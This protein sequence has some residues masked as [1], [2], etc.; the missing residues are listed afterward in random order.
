MARNTAKLLTLLAALLGVARAVAH[1]ALA[2]EDGQI[3]MGITKPLS[4]HIFR[5]RVQ[6]GRHGG[7]R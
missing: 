3:D 7:Q 6:S 1:H 4:A 2:L 5:V